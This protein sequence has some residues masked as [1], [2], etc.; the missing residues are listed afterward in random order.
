MKKAYK[1]IFFIIYIKILCDNKIVG[2]SVIPFYFMSTGISVL[3]IYDNKCG[4]FNDS[5]FIVNIKK[6]F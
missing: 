3:P 6:E 2:R 4:E 5:F 1:T